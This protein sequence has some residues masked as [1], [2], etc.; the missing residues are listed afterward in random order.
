[1]KNKLITLVVVVAAV[2]G[3]GWYNANFAPDRLAKAEYEKAKEAAEK[4]K[5]A[6]AEAE[7]TEDLPAIPELFKV[8]FETT[9]GDVI[10]EVHRDWAPLGAQRFHELVT[11]GIYDDNRLFRVVPGFVAQFGIPG[12]PELAGQWQMKRF[13]DD[14]VKESN[15]AGYVTFATSGRNSRTTQLFVNLADNQN[16]DRMGFAPFAKVIQGMDVVLQWN[17]EYGETPGKAQERIQNEGNAFLDK[18]YP[19]LDSIKKATIVE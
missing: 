8:K 6:K 14:P 7:K 13:K 4:T 2:G 16:L 9:K 5:E 17:G 15:L 1:M 11:K 3:L 19:K 12:K 10:L 18:E